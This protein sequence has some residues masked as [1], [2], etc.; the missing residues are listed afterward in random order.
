MTRQEIL[1]AMNAVKKQKALLV[2]QN[3]DLAIAGDVEGAKALIP[4][5]E[6][7]NELFM[8]LYEKLDEAA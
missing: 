8:D 5:I 2:E 6:E 3:Y 7:L 1:N 4:Q